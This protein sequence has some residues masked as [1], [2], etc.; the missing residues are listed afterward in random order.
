MTAWAAYTGKGQ[1]FAVQEAC[2]AI[3]VTCFVPR[4]VEV[5]RIRTRRR[6]DVFVTPYLPNYAFIWATDE[7]YHWL[8]DVKPVRSIMGIGPGSERLVRAFIDRVES[9]FAARMA[10]IEAGERV[11]EY[12][13]GDLLEIIA[14][15]FAGQ[16]AR[17]G[18]MIE[19]SQDIFPS[20]SA[21]MDLM[22]R[23]TRVKLDPLQVRKA[24]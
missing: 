14:G 9:D 8:K 21:N 19:T 2:E 20:I 24:G 15:P 12:N 6:P 10:Q 22:G 4:K 5:K 16:L 11:A 17:F 3:G 18:R 23:E 7:Q 13:P 1:E